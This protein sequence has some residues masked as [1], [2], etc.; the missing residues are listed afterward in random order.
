MHARRLCLVATL[1]RKI[2]PTAEEDAYDD[3]LCVLQLLSNLVTKDLVD[4]SEDEPGEKVSRRDGWKGTEPILGQRELP[5]VSLAEAL[6]SGE[7]FFTAEGG[8]VWVWQ[9]RRQSRNCR[10]WSSLRAPSDLSSCK[11]RP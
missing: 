10:F 5:L 7:N 2:D 8:M 9:S 1:Y 4:H 11:A 3:V 6:R